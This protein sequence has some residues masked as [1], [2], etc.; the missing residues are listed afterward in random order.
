MKY[1]CVVKDYM[2]YHDALQ[3]AIVA[4][5]TFHL[6][7]LTSNEVN[8]MG[9]SLKIQCTAHICIVIHTPQRGQ[10]VIFLS[11]KSWFQWCIIKSISFD[12]VDGY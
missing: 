10:R 4:P 12:Q 5:Q 2:L 3:Y 11:N 7:E 1:Q 6:V 9:K 8:Q